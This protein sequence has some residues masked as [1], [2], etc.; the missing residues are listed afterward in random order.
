MSGAYY[1]ILVSNVDVVNTVEGERNVVNAAEEFSD[2]LLTA[3]NEDVSTVGNCSHAC[4]ALM[5]SANILAR[6]LS[7]KLADQTVVSSH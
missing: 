2:A 6:S 7:D 5:T 1:C 4:A 3:I